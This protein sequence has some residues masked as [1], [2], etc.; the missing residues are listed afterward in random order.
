[1]HLRLKRRRLQNQ[2]IGERIE[3]QQLQATTIGDAPELPDDTPLEELPE[4]GRP[5]Q[6]PPPGW[7]LHAPNTS[8]S[9]FLSVSSA[10]D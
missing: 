3:R 10:L 6:R 5:L 9:L 8:V 4:A 2:L 7:D 1:M